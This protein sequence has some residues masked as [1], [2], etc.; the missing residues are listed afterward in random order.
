MALS[1]ALGAFRVPGKGNMTRTEIERREEAFQHHLDKSENYVAAIREAGDVP[2]WENP[3]KLAKLEN[4]IPG[5]SA[6]T[7]DERRRA[8]FM[9]HHQNPN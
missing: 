4:K 3:E 6:M 7:P 5:I 9:R 8:L 1:S 2:W